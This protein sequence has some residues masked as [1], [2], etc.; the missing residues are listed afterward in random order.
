MISNLLYKFKQFTFFE[1]E[2]K[3][4]SL[5]QSILFFLL[6]IS[7]LALILYFVPISFA[8][9]D[10]T[11]MNAIASGAMTG[12]PSEYL[13]FSNIII[14]HVLTFLF[15][16]IPDINWYSWYLIATFA[17][18]YTF[19]QYFFFKSRTGLLEKIT[20]HLIILAFLYPHILG[21]QFTKIAAIGLA[22]GFILIFSSTKRKEYFKITLGI[23][24]VITGALIR[25]DVFYMY[26]IL[27]AP[28]LFSFL[29]NKKKE[30]IFSIIAII[31]AF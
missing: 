9:N 20:I 12:E 7:E 6:C 1:I 16:T 3:K 15:S 2:T 27:T 28:F 10:D 22:G 19:I 30:F 14:G 5:S 11:T 4:L 26:L 8:G 31:V 23:I 13:L 21:I 18:G 29:I 17:L 24:L 25:K